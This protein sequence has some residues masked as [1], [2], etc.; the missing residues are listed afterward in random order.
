MIDNDFYPLIEE[1][2]NLLKKLDYVKNFHFQKVDFSNEKRIKVRIWICP[3]K[4]IA[5][6][7]LG[8]ESIEKKLIKIKKK[9]KFDFDIIDY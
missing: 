4:K 6:F 2:N 1:L 3:N 7:L 8:E 5:S 9:Y